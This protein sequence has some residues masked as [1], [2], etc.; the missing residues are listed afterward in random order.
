MPLGVGFLVLC[1]CSPGPPSAA[2]RSAMPSQSSLSS[3]TN[4]SA[5]GSPTSVAA[6]SSTEPGSPPITQPP[7]SLVDVDSV[8][9]PQWSSTGCPPSGLELQQ[10]VTGRFS[11]C[12]QV[13]GVPGGDYAIV[14]EQVL[15]PPADVAPASPAVPGL[16]LTAS[17]AS[18]PPGTAVSITGTVT[19][20]LS[21]R[22]GGVSLCW[23]GC[24]GGL[25]YPGE[26]LQWLSPTTFR[27]TIVVP[28]APWVTAWPPRVVPLTS[29]TYSIGV[30]CLQ[31]AHGCGLGGA[32]ATTS[33]RLDVPAAD[34]PSWCRTADSC[35]QMTVSPAHALPGQQITVTGFAPVAAMSGDGQ[36]LA[37][38]LQVIPAP[39]SGPSVQFQSLGKAEATEAYF[40]YGALTVMASPTFA[41]IN[42][43]SW[44]L[45]ASDGWQPVTENPAT[46][47]TTA[48]CGSGAI[49]IDAAGRTSTIPTGGAAQAALTAM[50]FPSQPGE[51]PTA[52]TCDTLALL[53][54]GVAGAPAVVAGFGV[55]P[56][57]QEPLFADVALLTRDGGK[58]WTPLPTPRGVKP[59]SFGGFRY[60][61]D[62]VTALFAPSGTTDPAPAVEATSDAGRTWIPAHM[63]CP[64]SGPCITFGAFQPGNCAKD[65]GYQSVIAS[66]DG[67]HHWAVT[68][69]DQN[70]D[71][72]WPAQLLTDAD[73]SEVLV[74]S[75]STFTV[76]R[77]TDGGRTWADIDIPP[78]PNR[79][80]GDGYD[81]A[82]IGLPGGS[83][84]ATSQDTADAWMLL[85]A[86]ATTWCAVATPD[87]TNQDSVFY[88]GPRAIGDQLWWLTWA[89]DSTGTTAHHVALAELSC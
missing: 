57:D 81:G 18:G 87:T 38:Q 58:S 7:S 82:V 8:A 76:E 13:G 26:T 49:T 32:E 56:P 63:T 80:V 27:T 35:A 9:V 16:Q 42:S 6:P 71:A 22:P 36:P 3:S 45:Q 12:L 47:S 11:Q 28:Q 65:G 85:R 72:C 75:S 83:L 79:P 67:G 39:T 60:G 31:E 59:D 46:P 33:F 70:L 5:A 73:G 44:R 29:G 4:P 88:G 25:A 43:T 17:P 86:G 64:T 52:L 23:D 48:W 74:D 2:Q 78:V 20:P 19:T 41:S 68:S 62:A 1:A 21:P 34:A 51:S 53:G 37:Y 10:S 24:P 40:G 69:L 15:S 55:E 50:G 30:Q 84:L 89:N 14:L 66:T 77:S 61:G 54:N